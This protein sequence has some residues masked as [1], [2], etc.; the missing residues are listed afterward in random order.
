[1]QTNND[2]R[3]I[4]GAW[5]EILAMGD[6]SGSV[7]LWRVA[8]GIVKPQH[9]ILNAVDSSQDLSISES[10]EFR[11]DTG[12][13]PWATAKVCLSPTPACTVVFHSHSHSHSHHHHHQACGRLEG[14]GRFDIGGRVG[15]A[16]RGGHPAARAR[17]RKR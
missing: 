17:L 6:A 7:A 5:D 2:K 9:F 10:V 15:I 13:A 3:K 11:F 16:D 1:M 14:P 8:G 4:I 12:L